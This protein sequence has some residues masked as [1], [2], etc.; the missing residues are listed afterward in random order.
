MIHEKFYLKLESLIKT[1]E[2]RRI[3]KR[4]SNPQQL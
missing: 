2:G 3:A 4:N 1:E